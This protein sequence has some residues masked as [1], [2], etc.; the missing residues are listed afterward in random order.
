MLGAESIAGW[1]E[2]LD[3]A[4]CMGI[5]F[6]GGEPT[7]HPQF[8]EICRH[9]AS[10]T[11]LAVTFTTHGHRLTPSLLQRI[12]GSIHFIRVSVDG[13]GATYEAQRG[14]RFSVLLERLRDAR[15]IA[16]LGINVVVNEHTV[17]ELDALAKMAH[18]VNASEILLLPQQATSTASN[19]SVD[20]CLELERWIR[21]YDGKVRL[22][23]SE[24]GSEGLPICDPLPKEKGLQ[25]Y[26]HIDASGIIKER[27]YEGP[28]VTIGRG[29]VLLAMNS[30]KA[31]MRSEV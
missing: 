27:S 25:A 10:R 2:E 17:R 9:A 20:V 6:G 12:A 30:L 3:S 18:D 15:K 19:A 31:M 5:G 1:L 28:G 4:G 16:P 14:R 23:T 7:L 13:V 21:N 22:A 29:G 11:Q 24:A 26:A 8:A